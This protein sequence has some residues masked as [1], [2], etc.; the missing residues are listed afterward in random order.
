VL[1]CPD[2]LHIGRDGYVPTTAGNNK[3]Y[4]VDGNLWIEPQGQNSQLINSPPEGTL[5]TIVVKGN[6]YFAD[7]LLYDND[8]MDGILFIALTDGESYTDQ[9]GNN[10]Y[11][12]GEPILHDD[13]NGAYDGPAEG[14]G[15]AFFGDPNGGPLGHVH[16][17]M[18]ADNHF[19]DHVLDGPG[20]DPLPFEVSGF[21]SAGE[22]IRIQRDYGSTHAQMILNYDA[23]LGSGEKTLPMF[24]TIGGGGKGDFSIMSWRIISAE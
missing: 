13:G 17:F 12:A 1:R 14:S 24:P 2:A 19:E 18:Y 20:G 4:F 10:Q 16:G 23:R 7:G 15:N 11:D 22:Q 5:I 9:N 8:E 6:I 3:T 21:F